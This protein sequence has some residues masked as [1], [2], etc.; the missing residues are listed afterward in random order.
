MY[1]LLSE[2]QECHR[3]DA[4]DAEKIAERN[5]L[6]SLR[7]PRRLGVSAVAF[8][9]RPS[10]ARSR[11]ALCDFVANQPDCQEGQ[12]KLRVSDVFHKSGCGAGDGLVGRVYRAL[13]RIGSA[14][15]ARVATS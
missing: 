5:Y 11:W 8:W 12:T 9:L 14:P 1:D 6:L 4:E 13:H 3:R 7:L 15:A 10:A 2:K